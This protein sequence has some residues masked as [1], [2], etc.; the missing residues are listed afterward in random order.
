VDEAFYGAVLFTSRTI[1]MYIFLPNEKNLPLRVKNNLVAGLFVGNS[2][3][4]EFWISLGELKYVVSCV[5]T[6]IPERSGSPSCRNY[7]LSVL[8]HCVADIYGAHPTKMYGVFH[9]LKVTTCQTGP[10]ATT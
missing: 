6:V 8:F 5:L 3:Q 4:H 10:E 9:N 1:P 2:G 7:E